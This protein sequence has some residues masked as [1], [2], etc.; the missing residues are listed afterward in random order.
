MASTGLLLPWLLRLVQGWRL[1]S[2]AAAASTLRLLWLML[3]LL[4]LLS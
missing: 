4:L 2:A 3:L 1:Q